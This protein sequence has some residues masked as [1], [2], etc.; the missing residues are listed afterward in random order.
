MATPHLLMITM[1]LIAYLDTYCCS[2]FHRGLSCLSS[3][4]IIDY[5]LRGA[6]YGIGSL[7]KRGRDRSNYS[8]DIKRRFLFCDCW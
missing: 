1:S 5:G 8:F 3:G 2:F 6:G 4:W 7:A